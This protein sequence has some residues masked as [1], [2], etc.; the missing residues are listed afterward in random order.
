[1]PALGESYAIVLPIVGQTSVQLP[2]A[3]LARDFTG[4]ALDDLKAR[5]KQN[6]PM[7]LGIGLGVAALVILLKKV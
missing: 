7:L 2:T 4:Y 5:A 6:V 3:Q 1:M